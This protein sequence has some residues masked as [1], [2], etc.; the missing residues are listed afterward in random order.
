MLRHFMGFFALDSDPPPTAQSVMELSPKPLPPLPP[1]LVLR[2][3]L[4]L[5]RR[6]KRMMARAAPAELSLV[7]LSFGVAATKML[8][9][10]ARLRIADR[11]AD[12]PKSAAALAAETQVDPEALHRTL[13]ALVSLGVFDMNERGEFLNDHLSEAL[14]TDRQDSF[15]HFAEYMASGSNV[16]AWNDFD[17]TLSAGGGGFGR[18][19]GMSVWDWFEQHDHERETFARA[20]MA[21][22]MIDAPNIAISYPWSEARVVC[23]VG[24]G[25]GTLLSELLVRHP[26]LRGVL[27]DAPSV[28]DSARPLLRSRGVLERV[29]LMPGSFFDSVPGGADTYVLKTVLHDWDDARCHK[30]LANTR[31]AMNPGHRLVIAEALVE[32]REALAPSLLSDVHM[33]TV[34]DGGKERSRVAFESLLSAAGF[35]LGRVFP[36]IHISVLEGIAV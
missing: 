26:H 2:S 13:R 28:L 15:A 11:L 9:A 17:A 33:M 29:E 34:C 31:R 12:G 7:E 32:E 14:R 22:T 21:L 8:G 16:D 36:T 24:G 19:M 35:K 6:L 27:V 5:R 20:M 23:D 3:A 18:A 10:V 4:A 25:R 30:I 1:D